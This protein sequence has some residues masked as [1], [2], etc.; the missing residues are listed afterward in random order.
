M[1]SSVREWKTMYSGLSEVNDEDW[2]V[3]R[4]T[5]RM[6][7]IEPRKNWSGDEWLGGGGYLC[8]AGKDYAQ[9]FDK[10]AVVFDALA[11]MLRLGVYTKEQYIEWLEDVRE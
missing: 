5:R 7:I 2:V 3:S 8:V 11:E 6:A 9:Y 4:I 1:M 10:L